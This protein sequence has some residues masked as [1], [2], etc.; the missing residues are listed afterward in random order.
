MADSLHNALT[1]D[2]SNGA[3]HNLHLPGY[4]VADVSAMNAITTGSAG[5]LAFV[6]SSGSYYAYSGSAWQ[7]M[8]SGAVSS[9]IDF[10][11]AQIFN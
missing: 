3:L 9:G 11:V 8:G 5:D 6:Q 7:A 2:A 1:N 4:S 10:L